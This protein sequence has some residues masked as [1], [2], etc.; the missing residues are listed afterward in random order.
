MTLAENRC[1][2][3]R[4]RLIGPIEGSVWA[5]AEEFAKGLIG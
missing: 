2:N 3:W 1:R 4:V 5:S